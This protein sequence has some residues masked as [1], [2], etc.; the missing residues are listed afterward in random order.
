MVWKVVSVE[1]EPEIT[2]LLRVVLHS[3][4]IEL[5]SADN[6]RDGLDLIRRTHPALVML[7]IMLPGNVDGWAVYDAMRAEAS[8]ERTPVIMLSVLSEEPARRR[9]FA[10]SDIDLYVTKP[11]DTVDLRSAIE[12]MLG[13]EG[14]LWASPQPKVAHVFRKLTRTR[15]ESP[16]RPEN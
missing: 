3:P 15:P 6:G 10:A 8:F 14:Q 2:E 1:D 7:D 9:A 4:H 5:L 11:F 12:R 13:V 16:S